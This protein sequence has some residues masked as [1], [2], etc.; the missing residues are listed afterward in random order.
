MT[1]IVR[2]CSPS[3]DPTATVILLPASIVSR[4]VPQTSAAHH[5]GCRPAGEQAL[6][7]VYASVVVEREPSCGVV[8]TFAQSPPVPCANGSWICPPVGTAGR[9]R[10]FHT[11]SRVRRRGRRT[12][13]SRTWARSPGYGLIPS[14][15]CSSPSLVVHRPLGHWRYG[16]NS[17]GS[18]HCMVVS[19]S[20][21]PTVPP[22]VHYRADTAGTLVR[23][24]AD[25]I[26][27][28]GRG[29]QHGFVRRPADTADRRC[30]GSPT[31]LRQ[32]SRLSA[33]PH[34]PPGHCETVRRC[35][36]EAATRRPRSCDNRC[37]TAGHRQEG[38]RLRGGSRR[39]R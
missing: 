11:D 22:R 31:R 18:C 7:A 39:A 33:P 21:E 1:T 23:D 37:G 30:H 13:K 2:T 17:P 35:L 4:S 25:D 27:D 24:G 14:D 29:L 15:R 16:H 19:R 26:A 5:R 10:R 28:L 8:R 34:P 12:S 36:G 20:V 32:R 9:L 6:L 3:A 38:P